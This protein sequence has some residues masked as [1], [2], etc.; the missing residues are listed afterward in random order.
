MELLF[1]NGVLRSEQF[2][3]IDPWLS[4]FSISYYYFGYLI[5]G[6][7][8]QL[9]GVP[10]EFAFN[11]MLPTLFALTATGAFAIGS[12]LS[13]ARAA[14]AIAAARRERHARHRA[15]AAGR[16]PRA[17][18]RDHE[19]A[20]HALA[21]AAAGR[22]R[23]RTCRPRTTAGV[24]PGRQLVVVPRDARHRHAG[25]D[26]AAL[27]YTINEFPFFSFVLGDMHPHVLA[28]PFLFVALGFALNLLRAPGRL[29]LGDAAARPLVVLPLG[30]LFGAIGFLNT[31][32]MPTMLFV[33]AGA[34]GCTALL[35][36]GVIDRPLVREVLYGS[37]G[38][39]LLCVRALP[40]LLPVVPL[41]GLGLRAGRHQDAAEALPRCSGD[42]STCPSRRSSCSS[43]PRPGSRRRR[44]SWTR[45]RRLGRHDRCWPRSR[46]C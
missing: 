33:L 10:A 35:E 17:G 45:R 1:L 32:D 40:A 39:L 24:L 16:E 30:V 29:D 44:E 46:S 41:A 23:S 4:G 28:L 13:P 27:D 26:R 5:A 3:P 11:L 14:A 42:R 37:V 22:S 19:R 7:L 34:F 31:W 12:A 8:A 18:A 2:P 38:A 6:M 25:Q 15:G 9:A 21:G 20:P 43:S 36:R